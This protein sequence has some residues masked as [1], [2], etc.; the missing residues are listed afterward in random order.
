MVISCIYYICDSVN[1]NKRLICEIAM[2][3]FH[4][5]YSANPN[6]RHIAT[7]N[8][9]SALAR[10]QKGGIIAPP[11]YDT[12]FA[13]SNND[14]RYGFPKLP[15]QYGFGR[16]GGSVQVYPVGKRWNRSPRQFG[17]GRRQQG[18]I[19]AGALGKMILKPAL[20]VAV[21]MLAKLG[22]NQIG[23]LIKKKKA[24]K[25]RGGN[26]RNLAGQLVESRHF[27]KLLTDPLMHVTE[28]ARSYGGEGIKKLQTKLA[29]AIKGSPQ[30]GGSIKRRLAGDGKIIAGDFIRNATA[31]LGQ[32]ATRNFVKSNVRK[33]VPFFK[34]T[35][36]KKAWGA[37]NGALQ[38]AA[39]QGKKLSA[40]GRKQQR[41]G[42]FGLAAMLGKAILPAVAGA[43]LEPALGGILKQV[44]LGKGKGSHLLRSVRR[45][46]AF[47]KRLRAVLQ[48]GGRG[49]AGGGGDDAETN[50]VIQQVLQ[51]PSTSTSKPK[52]KKSKS[53]ILWSMVNSNV[54]TQFADK[55]GQKA[56][57]AVLTKIFG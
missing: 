6:L 52:K 49:N 30:K 20:G 32:K 53:D 3:D 27:N 56:S 54:V 46:N 55:F 45:A 40:S 33:K 47:Q 25:Q 51:T 39:K 14:F 41:G 21:P 7:M 48:R 10:G 57:D 22:I 44:G 35:I 37:V 8:Y 17:S 50:A 1:K 31:L 18:G 29:R 19:A 15:P 4:L 2:S 28:M 23:K 11:H 24:K 9:K 5:L 13:P 12:M 38:R 36:S 26:L 34:N 42:A 16:G 43:V